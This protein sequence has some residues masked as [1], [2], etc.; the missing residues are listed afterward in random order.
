M[1]LEQFKTLINTERN[2]FS[3]EGQAPADRFLQAR[4]AERLISIEEKLD[5]VL[6]IAVL[7]TLTTSK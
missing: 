1:D 5:A 3:H 6:K 4:M 7:N 2:R